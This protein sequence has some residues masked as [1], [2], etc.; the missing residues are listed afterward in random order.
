MLLSTRDLSL[1]VGVEHATFFTPHSKLWV[2]GSWIRHVYWSLFTQGQ[3]FHVHLTA[4]R[5]MF[6]GSSSPSTATVGDVHFRFH[7][8]MLVVTT[9]KWRTSA[10]VTSGR[11]H[12]GQL[13]INV[14]IQP[15]YDVT[16]DPVAPHGLLGQTYDGDARP[17]HGKRDRYD[18]LDDGSLTRARTRAG[19]NVTTRAKAEGAI[20][21]ESEMYRIRSPFDTNFAFSRFGAH[22]ASPRNASGLRSMYK[23]SSSS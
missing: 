5:P 17:L 13:R 9:P 1:A 14:R 23:Y 4:F 18:V 19:G 6:N 10:E 8:K 2:H 11:P 7:N 15:L 21:G 22:Q 16:S 3:L 20:E 12:P